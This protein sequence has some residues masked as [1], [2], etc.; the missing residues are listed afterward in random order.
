MK[1]NVLSTL[2]IVPLVGMLVF[3]G[4]GKVDEAPNNVDATEDA[5]Q[6]PVDL[7]QEASGFG[8]E[9]ATGTPTEAE[10]DGDVETKPATESGENEQV[11]DKS[12]TVED[13]NNAII[14]ENVRMY[15]DTEEYTLDMTN[16]G[17]VMRIYINNEAGKASMD[18][19]TTN[20]MVYAKF[21]VEGDETVGKTP[22]TADNDY[23]SMSP[24]TGSFASV[25]Y[26]KTA[27]V[28]GKSYDVVKA[29][30]ADD[31][32]GTTPATYNVYIN[33]ETGMADILEAEDGSMIHIEKADSLEIPEELKGADDFEK[34]EDVAMMMMGVMFAGQT[35]SGNEISD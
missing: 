33:V 4:C 5:E 18:M 20:D 25:E 29:T 35:S 11:L 15:Y 28:D 34:P 14:S 9:V 16:V 7:R 1:K 32:D 10:A 6:A 24:E 26:I 23:S 8:G 12:Y 30:E 2:M 13:V 22:A 31:E 21:V 17:G 27:I 3:T 19:Y